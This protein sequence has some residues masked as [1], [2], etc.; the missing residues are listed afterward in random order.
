MYYIQSICF[1]ASYSTNA[2]GAKILGKGPSG[3][4]HE[5]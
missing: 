1:L 3:V 5:E 4:E 2:D